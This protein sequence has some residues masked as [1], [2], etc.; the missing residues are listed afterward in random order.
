MVSAVMEALAS[1]SYKTVRPAYYETTLRTKIAQDPQSAEM[2][3]IIIDNIYIDAGIIYT[4]ALNT[5][6]DKFRQIMGG[7]KNTVISQ[8]KSVS[9]SSKRALERMVMRLDKIIQE[10]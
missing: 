5:F 10:G 1:A 2:F 4:N 8:Y 6:H 9:G 3:D 7:G